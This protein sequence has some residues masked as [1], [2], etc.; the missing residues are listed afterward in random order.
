MLGMTSESTLRMLENGKTLQPAKLRTLLQESAETAAGPEPLPGRRYRSPEEWMAA[1][2]PFLGYRMELLAR[3]TEIKLLALEALSALAADTGAADAPPGGTEEAW[4]DLLNMQRQPG[5][6]REEQNRAESCLLAAGRKADQA[7]TALAGSM[8][9]QDPEGGW[10]AVFNLYPKRRTMFTC[11]RSRG[12]VSVYRGEQRLPSQ[13][14]DGDDATAVELEMDG[15]S[16]ES[17]RVERDGP[18][19][20]HERLGNAYAF[21]NDVMRLEVQRDGRI[22][23]LESKMNGPLLK[24]GNLVRGRWRDASG[25]EVRFRGEDLTGEARVVRGELFD[26]IY[27]KRS[28]A[29]IGLEMVLY[30]P[31][32]SSRRVEI[33]LDLTLSEEVRADFLASGGSFWVEWQSTLETP[34]ILCDR[35]F[36]WRACEEGEAL[37]SANGVTLT[38]D[39]SGL[40]LDH[41]GVTRAWSRDG[42]LYLLLGKGGAEAAE[43][44]PAGRLDARD[45]DAPERT[46]WRY[47]Y[48]IDLADE[49][50]PEH[51]FGRVM[52]YQFPMLP[53]R[54]GRPLNIPC[55]LRLED[56]LIPTALFRR[57]GRSI[58]RGW[59]AAGAGRLLRAAGARGFETGQ[60]LPPFDV[61]EKSF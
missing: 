25:R 54:T 30:L 34:R 29:G 44:A 51:L 12:P 31:H 60:K 20:I 38:R 18:P 43:D 42:A 41:Q 24:L 4:Q 56:G 50:T 57:N 33:M 2:T 37:L 11:I 32:R 40:M 59:N 10:A 1:E 7:W 61:F 16:V 3:R 48:A 23:R 6:S 47:F 13:Y 36:G 21:E 19:N 55:M 22:T 9:G 17:L 35:P 28:G 46:K 53:L 5:M 8:T 26:N 58:V 15:L 39:G 27:L 14:I 52:S 45:P 49:D